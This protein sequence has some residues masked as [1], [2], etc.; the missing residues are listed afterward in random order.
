MRLPTNDD[1]FF[2]TSSG[3]LSGGALSFSSSRVATNIGPP[4]GCSGAG[5]ALAPFFGAGFFGVGFFGSGSSAVFALGSTISSLSA[6]SSGG[7]GCPLT[8]LSSTRTGSPSLG[9]NTTRGSLPSS[10]TVTLAGVSFA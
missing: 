4:E 10:T 6:S 3:T 9:V 8:M 2:F 1:T 7:L 5:S